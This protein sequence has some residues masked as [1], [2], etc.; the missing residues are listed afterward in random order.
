MRT[1]AAFFLLLISCQPAS[2]GGAGA[3]GPQGPPGPMGTMGA[4]G[5]DGA[6]AVEKSG[7]R[8]QL[9]TPA[10]A[11][12]DGAVIASDVRVIWDSKLQ[13]PCAISGATDGVFRCLPNEGNSAGGA[14]GYT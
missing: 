1:A 8:I 4:S 10:F 11:L 13:V 7:S 3:I 12:A 2:D 5:K 6:G 9:K 14:F